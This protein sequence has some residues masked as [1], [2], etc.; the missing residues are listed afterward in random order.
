[1][2][3]RVSPIVVKVEPDSSVVVLRFL[4]RSVM[5]D[6]AEISHRGTHSSKS[7]TELARF[8]AAGQDRHDLLFLQHTAWLGGRISSKNC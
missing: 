4:A 3:V 6:Q 8:L 5:E 2:G 1:M 7:A